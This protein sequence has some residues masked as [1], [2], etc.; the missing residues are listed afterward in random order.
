MRIFK[1]FTETDNLKQ[2]R[3]L[4]ENITPIQLRELSEI[5]NHLLTKH[6][7]LDIGTRKKLRKKSDTL[8]KVV[9]RG[10]NYTQKKKVV[11]QYGEGKGK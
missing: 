1:F 3:A 4:S 11:N 2:K 10:R 5:C 9:T 7:K 8:R 6:C